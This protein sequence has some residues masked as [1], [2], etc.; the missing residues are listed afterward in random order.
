MEKA[1][2]KRH[3]F[4]DTRNHDGIGSDHNAKTMKAINKEKNQCNNLLM[5][6]KLLHRS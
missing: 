6:L 1:E 5:N 3:H 2:N 4:D